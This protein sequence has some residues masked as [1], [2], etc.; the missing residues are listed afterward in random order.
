MKHIV[1]S[2]NPELARDF[3]RDLLRRRDLTLST[4][5]SAA[6]VLARVR[7]GADICFV[8]RILPEG[9]ATLVLDALRDDKHTENLPVV[10]VT[11]VGAPP[12]DVLDARARGFDD[13][14]ELPAAPGALSLMVARLLGLPLREDERFAVRVHVFDSHAGP[15]AT[16]TDDGYLGTSLDLSEHGML[17]KA[18]RDVPPGTELT[19]RFALPA[20]GGELTLRARVLRSD[21]KTEPPAKLLALSFDSPTP[22]ERTALREYL[23]ALIGGRPFMWQVTLEDGRQVV[24]LYGVLRGDSD[25]EALHSLQ[26]DVWF[27]LRDF[28]RIGS[29]SVQ[30]WIEFVRK[31]GDVKRLRLLE[32]PSAFIHQANLIPNLL[33]RQEVVSFFAPYACQACGLDEKKLIDVAADLDGGK[34]RTPPV[35][36]CTG[37]HQP[38]QFDDLPEQYFSFLERM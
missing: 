2:H 31:L 9:D 37:C 11:A 20:R 34:R 33:E 8:D 23:T 14:V 19:L 6:E 15:D 36:Q 12:S 5:R 28:R 26:G 25:L 1:A 29:D 16:L 18:K 3:D 21:G 27:R 10:L 13:V 17:L 22:V 7:A 24:S 38:L 30:R 35:F 4:G 32:C